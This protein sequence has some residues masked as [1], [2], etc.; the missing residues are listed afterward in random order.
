[1]QRRMNCG[2]AIWVVKSGWPKEPCLTPPAAYSVVCVCCIY[3]TVS[4]AKTDEPSRCRVGCDI[5]DTYP[6]YRAVN[7]EHMLSCIETVELIEIPV[8]VWSWMRP[9]NHVWWGLACPAMWSLVKNL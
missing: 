5:G 8:G 2:D 4:Y 9:K 7:G 6:F 3:T 1:M